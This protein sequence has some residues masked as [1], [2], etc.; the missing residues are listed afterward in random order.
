MDLGQAIWADAIE[1]WERKERRGEVRADAIFDEH[2]TRLMVLYGLLS[3]HERGV[4]SR[5]RQGGA[6]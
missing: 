3:R 4:G 5:R 2:V 6:R 1:T